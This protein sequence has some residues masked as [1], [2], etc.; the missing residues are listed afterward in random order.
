MIMNICEL[1]PHSLRSAPPFYSLRKLASPQAPAT[2]PEL[3]EWLTNPDQSSKWGGKL[4]VAK[5]IEWSG[6]EFRQAGCSPNYLAGWWS[7][8]CCKHSMRTGQPFQKAARNL[9]VPTYVFT[10]GRRNPEVAQALVSVAR[11]TACFKTMDAYANFLLSRDQ[12]L[13][14]S[15]LTRCRQDDGLLGWCFGDCHADTNGLVGEPNPDHVHSECWRQDVNGEHLI[16]VSNSFVVWDKPIFVASVVEKQSRYGRN[17]TPKNFGT[18][19]TLS[20][21][22]A[23]G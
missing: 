12:D 15:R 16:L 14:S 5:T 19:L 6:S 22:R 2:F 13:I 1:T 9:S 8:A 18:L 20:G 7:L 3:A 21:A 23:Y 4:Y 10:L 17:V 11:I